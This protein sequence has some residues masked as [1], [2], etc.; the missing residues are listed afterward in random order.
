M[1]DLRFCL[2][3][4]LYLVCSLYAISSTGE[5]STESSCMDV[6]DIEPTVVVKGVPTHL[7]LCC[8]RSMAASYPTANEASR[9]VDSHNAHHWIQQKKSLCPGKF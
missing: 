5:N 1:Y 7:D 4:H 3:Y 2:C 6:K 8:K 9:T